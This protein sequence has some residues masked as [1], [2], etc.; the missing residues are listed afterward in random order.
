MST[1]RPW[2]DADTAW[3]REHYADTPAVILRAALDRADWQIYS[4]AFALG[5]HKTPEYLA[6]EL[7]GRLRGGAVGAPWRFKPG[8]VTWNAGTTARRGGRGRGPMPVVRRERLEDGRGV[9]DRHGWRAA[10]G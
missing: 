8:H 3:L 5:L 1:R 2:T 4:K 6:G 7:G 9:R 10:A